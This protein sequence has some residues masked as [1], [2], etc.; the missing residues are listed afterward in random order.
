MRL[1]LLT[2]AAL[3]AFVSAASANADPSGAKREH[4][5][6]EN[7][8]RIAAHDRKSSAEPSGIR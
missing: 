7:Q 3:L 2:A 8:I 5:A 4:R 6:S 1:P